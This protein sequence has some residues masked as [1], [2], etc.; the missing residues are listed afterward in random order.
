M[1]QQLRQAL[2]VTR[3]HP[4]VAMPPLDLVAARVF[5]KRVQVESYVRRIGEH[6][7]IGYA[8]LLKA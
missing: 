2:L 4:V 6:L 7:Q 3:G 8:D 5:H 1:A